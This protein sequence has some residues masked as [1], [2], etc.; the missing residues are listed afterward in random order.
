VKT[1]R[2]PTETIVL[3][4]YFIIT[5]PSVFAGISMNQTICP[6]KYVAS[7]T[8]CVL[9]LGVLPTSFGQPT[10]PP[11]ESV[12]VPNFT[13]PFEVAESTNSIREV[14]LLV[15]KDR[16]RRWISVARQSVDSEKFAF[17]A[18]SDGE[19]WFAFRTITT[20]GKP[21]PFRGHPDLRV[22]VN[23][24]GAAILP[25]SQP[26][27]SGPVA[28]PKPERFK[29]EKVSKPQLQPEKTD[30]LD[31]I[32]SLTRL[33]S[34]PEEVT[35]NNPPVD[36]EKNNSQAAQKRSLLA[37]KL[38][39]FEPAEPEKHDTENLLDDLLSRMSPFMDVQPVEITRIMPNTHVAAQPAISQ[40]PADPPA[41]SISRIDLGG[42]ETKPQVVVQW[43]T[44]TELWQDAQIDIFR[45][46]TEEGPWSP[47]AI[48]LGNSGGYWWFLT[49]EDM[50][51]FYVAVRIRSFRGGTQMDMTQSAITI[52]PAKVFTVQSAR[53]P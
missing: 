46:G 4:G 43:H 29:G 49:P 15:S 3:S 9:F 48:N 14:E 5:L 36:D 13:I 6:I 41:G 20:A 16:G 21:L 17:R 35:V 11:L 7:W 52:D 33:P 30:E 34:F 18:D 40:V 23:T 31:G 42:T 2:F 22:A 47:I 51:P 26:S 8:V 45:G 12:N 39:G 19:Y 37:P 1:A 38:P 28:P 50:K 25:P 53:S 27:Q 24:N 10:L 32:S 44:G